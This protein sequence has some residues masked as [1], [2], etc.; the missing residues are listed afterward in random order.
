[1]TIGPSSGFDIFSLSAKLTVNLF[2]TARQPLKRGP[3]WTWLKRSTVE[4]SYGLVKIEQQKKD[5]GGGISD[6][7]LTP[8]A[9]R[10][11]GVSYKY[12]LIGDDIDDRD[13]ELTTALGNAFTALAPAYR[14]PANPNLLDLS[15][16]KEFLA[17]LGKV[18]DLK[19]VKAALKNQFRLS[20]KVAYTAKWNTNVRDDLALTLSA[21]MG[22]GTSPNLIGITG[23]MTFTESLGEGALKPI[24]AVKGGMGI[25]VDLTDGVKLAHQIVVQHF[26][27]DGFSGISGVIDTT[28]RTEGNLAQ[29]LSFRLIGGQYLALA[30]KELHLGTDDVDMTIGTEF[31]WKF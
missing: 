29:V 19:A 25:D 11:F 28:K 12:G 2:D 23:D 17:A 4:S 16:E 31:G 30:I 20:T 5:L 15:R 3:V 10:T 8:S 14:D 18:V 7:V 24:R 13:Q 9:P 6:T 22:L 21:S 27:G 1:M 26:S